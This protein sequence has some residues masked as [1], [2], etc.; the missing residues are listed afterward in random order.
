MKHYNI[1]CRLA[2]PG[3]K[4]PDPTRDKEL[5]TVIAGRNRLDFK[6]LPSLFR[7]LQLYQH[8]RQVICNPFLMFGII[9]GVLQCS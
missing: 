2:Y 8:L 7:S 3:A 1:L 4:N 5:H 6:L 9:V